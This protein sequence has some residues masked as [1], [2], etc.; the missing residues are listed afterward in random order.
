VNYLLPSTASQTQTTTS[1]RPGV[2][3][4]HVLVLFADD[5]ERDIKGLWGPYSSMD[6]ATAALDELRQ[7]PLEGYW[8]VR[9]LNKFVA[10]K[11]ANSDGL[12]RFTWQS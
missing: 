6:V 3:E 12:M 2:E 8:D 1:Q 4:W 10:L 11:A 7:W 5:S 9:R